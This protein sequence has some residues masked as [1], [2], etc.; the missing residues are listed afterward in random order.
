M[1]LAQ[2]DV[3]FSFVQCSSQEGNHANTIAVQT[4]FYSDVVVFASHPGDPGS[5]D[6]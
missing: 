1:K 3:S 5:G 4:G 2:L 6:I